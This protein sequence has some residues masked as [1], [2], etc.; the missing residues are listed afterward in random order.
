[1]KNDFHWNM[2]TWV[3]SVTAAM[4][5]DMQARVDLVIRVIKQEIKYSVLCKIGMEP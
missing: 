1:M 2:A 5:L 4:T 3:S